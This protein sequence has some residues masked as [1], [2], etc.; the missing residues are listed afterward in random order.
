MSIVDS[1]AASC[2]ECHRH[3]TTRACV[4]GIVRYCGA[5]CQKV[6][7]ARHK[8]DCPPVVLREVEGK[9]MGLVTTRRVGAGKVIITECPIIKHL[10]WTEN[11]HQFLP[12][13]QK[14]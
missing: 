2:S 12:E 3:V 14:E 11:F 10:G 8:Q 9:G 5:T 13:V 6:D 1:A 4:C 7:W